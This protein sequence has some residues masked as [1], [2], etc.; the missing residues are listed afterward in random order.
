MSL[1][2]ESV[3]TLIYENIEGEKDEK[4]SI[5][6]LSNK[7]NNTFPK[8]NLKGKSRTFGKITD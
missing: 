4:F 3:N 1:L 5:F 7:E 8:V 6:W 2:T